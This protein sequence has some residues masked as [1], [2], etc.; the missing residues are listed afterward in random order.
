MTTT[1]LTGLVAVAVVALVGNREHRSMRSSRRALLDDA[2]PALE[3]PVL[4]HGGDDFP[5]LAG[6]HRGIGVRVDLISDTMTLRRLPQLW[7]SVTKLVPAPGTP[8]VAVLV[9]PTGCEFYAL[10]GSLE[11]ALDVPALLPRETLA[12]GSSREAQSLLDRL[13]RP[14]ADIMTDPRVKEIAVTEKGLRIVRQAAEGRRG[15]HLLLR[16]AVFD[17]AKVDRDDVLRLLCEIDA[18][19]AV[20]HARAGEVVAA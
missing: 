6:R 13:A 12:R 5:R 1:I 14:M 3:A 9:R 15:E 8:R 16:Q 2:A 20:V 10:T 11:H 4:D 7:L 19:S 17:D 18:L